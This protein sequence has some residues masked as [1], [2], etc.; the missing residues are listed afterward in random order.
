MTRGLVVRRLWSALTAAPVRTLALAVLVALV[1]SIAIPVP[2]HAASSA[3]DPMKCE[4][5]VIAEIVALNAVI[6]SNRMGANLPQAMIFALRND[7]EDTSDPNETDWTKWQPGAVG[8]KDYKRPRPIVL[9]VNQGECLEIHFRNLLCDTTAWIVSTT[10]TASL[11]VQGLNWSSAKSDDG[12]WV[13]TNPSSLVAPVGTTAS[14]LVETVGTTSVQVAQG[15]SATYKLYAPQE[16]PFLLYSTADV[17]TTGNSTGKKTPQGKSGSQG[18]DGGQLQQG[19]FG[20]VLVQPRGAEYY[21]SQVNFEDLCL[22]TKNATWNNATLKCQQQDPLEPPQIDYQAT[23]PDWHDRKFLPVLN[24][25]CSK[26]KTPQA[27]AKGLCADGEL[28]HSDLTAIITGPDAGRFPADDAKLPTFH[29]MPVSPDRLQPYREF[30]LIYHEMMR[31][32]QAFEPLYDDNQLTN[33]LLAANDNFAINYGMGGIGSEVLANRFAVGPMGKC[34]DCKYEEF[35]LS[36]WSNGDPAMIV[37]QPAS[38]GCG[39]SGTGFTTFNCL[40]HKP[41]T[42]AYYPDDPSNVYHSYLWD[43]TKFRI[44][45]G[46]SDLHHIHHLHAHQWL[47]S[48]NSSSGHYLDSQAIGPG[49]A[50]TL[51]TVYNGG[52]NKNL[53]VGDAI[54]HCHFYPHFASGMWSLW[55]VHDTF[56]EGTELDAYPAGRPRKNSRALPDGEIK[57]GTPTVALVPLPTK[58]MAPLPAPVRLTASGTHVEVCSDSTFTKCVSTLDAAGDVKAWKNPGYPFFIAGIGGSRASHPPLD[59]ARACSVSGDSCSNLDIGA[60]CPGSGGVCQALDGGLPRHVVERTNAPGTHTEAAKVNPLDFSK[61]V[62][63]ATGLGLPE[64][65]TLIE[66]VAM[67][68]HQEKLHASHTPEG[69]SALFRTNGSKPVSGAPYADPCV[70][71]EGNVPKGLGQREYWAADFQTDA[72]YNKEGWHFPQQRMLALWGDVFPYMGIDQAKRPPQPFFFRASSNDCVHYVL[73]NL[74]P[75]SYEL[76]DFQVRTPTDIL[77][78]HIHLVKFD[79]TSSDGAANG[80]NYEDGTLGPEEVTERIG[81]FNNGDWKPA[82]GGPAKPLKPSFIKFF[83]ADP[84]CPPGQSGKPGAPDRCQCELISSPPEVANYVKGGRWC[85][86]QATVQR[87]YVDPT[88]NNDGQDLTL[89]TVFTHDHFGPSTHQQ[90][91]LYAALVAEPEGSTWLDNAEGTPLGGRTATQNGVSIHDGGPTSWD[92]VIQT[93]AIKD[94]FREF[95]FAFQDSTLMY[96]PFNHVK[97]KPPVCPG[98]AACGFCS[99][100]RITPCDDDRS[101]TAYYGKVCK[102]VSLPN[103]GGSASTLKK[104][105]NFVVGIPSRNS[106]FFS[107]NNIFNSTTLQ[108]LGWDTLPIDPPPSG[109]VV[110]NQKTATQPETITL[111]GG[112]YNFSVNYRSEPV[113]PRISGATGGKQ[114]HD[115]S[116][117]YRSIPRN[118]PGEVPTYS[119][120]LTPGVLPEDPFTPLLRAYAGDDIQLRIVVGAHQNP[121]EFTLNGGKWLFEPSNVNSGWRNTEAMGISEHFEFLMRLPVGIVQPDPQTKPQ[122]WTD[123]LYRPSATKKAQ[124]SGSWGL[125]RAY[126]SKQPHLFALPGAAPPPAAPVPVCP[127]ALMKDCPAAGAPAVTDG[128]GHQL[129][130]FYVEATSIADLK[131]KPVLNYNTALSFTSPNALL[132]L[133]RD[134]YNLAIN[135]KESPG[136]NPTTAQGEPLVLRAAA[137][138]CIKVQLTNHLKTVGSGASSVQ[139]P[140]FPLPPVTNSERN[141]INVSS[142]TSRDVGLRPQ[143]VSYDVAQS[144]GFNAGWNPVQTVPPPKT[145]GGKTTT[146]SKTYTWYAGNIDTA[147]AE[148]HIP[149]EFG[150]TSLL[151]TDTL[152]HPGYGLF[153]ALIIEPERATWDEDSKSRLQALVDS[154]GHSF[155]EFVLLLQDDINTGGTVKGGLNGFDLRSE[156]LS[157]KT[158][159]SCAAGSDPGVVAGSDPLA[160]GCPVL[161]ANVTAPSPV[162]CELSDTAI[163]N[164]KPCGYSSTSPSQIPIQTPLLCAKKG[165]EA[166]F[167]L[168][169][170][171]GAVTNNVFELFGHTF[172]EEPYLTR[173]AHCQA[174]VTHANPYASQVIAADPLHSNECPDGTLAAG[175]SVAEWKGSRM[176][177]GSDNHFDIVVEMA[178]GTHQVAGDYLYRTFSA[179]HFA[180]GAWGIFRV[181]DGPPTSEQCP[182]GPKPPK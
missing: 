58:A 165:A 128:Q 38:W 9:R 178:G 146:S 134:D 70:D 154:G 167:R 69:A 137:G 138:D 115:L 35:F 145:V 156:R 152:N 110:G 90:T 143:L 63:K 114:T 15:G 159:R 23:Y 2:M 169:H 10:P 71:I 88:L 1:A 164:G 177:V 27:I 107:T 43:H 55:R 65:G 168:L 5:T 153:G 89:R 173:S 99:N 142:N 8:L 108:A 49:S 80:W 61:E 181:T 25:M 122:P 135:G 166:R 112:T 105:C 125:L 39:E 34:T 124:Q 16:G 86:S 180:A 4:G 48:P 176:G 21:R 100:D 78:E 31:A 33:M 85:G 118:L 175:P 129:R 182:S 160:T 151:P 75:K 19:L 83:G 30:A 46:G 52:G 92:A 133:Q 132:Y 72:V 172:S 174:P 28:V 162:T 127:A 22:A 42:Q 158:A 111:D 40:S 101:S 157:G 60:N 147:A 18:G 67:K 139:L 45:H 47:H 84:S 123:Y 17:F 68:Y 57:T 136:F 163:C 44:L 13:G 59:F 95:L 76:D 96:L 126:D 130:C 64:D 161:P 91:G 26:K 93:A 73:A 37:D 36:S 32:V 12:S 79:V 141:N 140:V 11:H 87:W 62:V 155:R 74:V 102:D 66:K 117:V 150:A 109:M 81:A 148:P 179:D 51:E 77:G 24:M 131:G 171:G 103:P 106:L 14:S 116:H 7:V 53:T 120:D 121:H 113:Y 82:P 54:F 119:K 6:S 144:D 149:I 97:T 3:G 170:P 104:S 94:S 56:E 29:D 20:A 41:A 98:G 50:F